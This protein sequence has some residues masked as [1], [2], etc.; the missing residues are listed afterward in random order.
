MA[1]Q[2]APRTLGN[3]MKTPPLTLGSWHVYDKLYVED[4]VALIS[5]AIESGLS[6]FDVGTYEIN[7]P[8]Q[9]FQKLI[10]PMHEGDDAVAMTREEAMQGTVRVPP[11]YTDVL[12]GTFLRLSGLPRD[13][14]TVQTKL[15][16]IEYPDTTF[17]Q[18]LDTTFGRVGIDY[19]ELGIVGGY[20]HQ[21]DLEAVVHDAADQIAAGRIGA[22]GINNWRVADLEEADRIAVRDGLPRPQVAQSKYSVARR[23]VA[24]SPRYEALYQ[25]T[26]ISLQPSDL[27]EGGLLSGKRSGTREISPDNGAVYTRIEQ[28]V[29]PRLVSL[30]ADLGAS[31][32]QVAIA[33][34]LAYPHTSSAVMGMSTLDQLRDNIRAI[35]LAETHGAQI[36]AALDDLW[37][38]RDVIDPLGVS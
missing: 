25:Q 30:A 21:V 6:H 31:A 37:I 19:A 7:Y 23:T 32:A 34:V 1:Y 35:E 14:Y 22:W 26:D 10:A 20:L 36:R 17:G 29:V 33:Y 12:F 2:L 9:A 3:G 28:E 38:D 8:M 15:W 5:E 24:I 4:G 13:A 16:L 27:L 11:T 18:Q